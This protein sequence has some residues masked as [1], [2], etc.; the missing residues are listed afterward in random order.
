MYY[1]TTSL[2]TYRI[3]AADGTMGKI[4]DIYFDDELWKIRYIIVD[5]RK[6]LP[7][8][9][10]LLSPA[11][12][13]GVNEVN[14]TLEVE[15]DKEVIKK[16]PTVPEESD[17]TRDTEGRL[18][19][20]F[21]WH[22]YWPDDLLVSGDQRPL[23]LFQAQSERVQQS[24]K[25]ENRERL[26][27][28]HK[29]YNLRSFEEFYGARV[30]GR[31]GKL[32]KMSDFVYDQDWQIHYIVV[33]TG[34]VLDDEY[35]IYPVKKVISADWYEKDLYLDETVHTLEMDLKYFEKNQILDWLKQ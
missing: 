13:I 5:T 16:S 25:S 22:R 31:D 23:G 35:L 34:N 27:K 3:D 10:V 12:I 7:G 26:L 9:K 18:V 29:G 4:N 20:Y 21:G 33:K 8:R 17:L 30:H 15:Y 19:N 11:S 32:G 2:Q 14:E 6:W 24:R 1:L 28:E